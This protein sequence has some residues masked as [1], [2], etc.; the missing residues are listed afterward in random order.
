MKINASFLLITVALLIFGCV[1]SSPP[2]S[3]KFVESQPGIEG[4]D[5][6]NDP[7]NV[8]FDNENLNSS[9]SDDTLG[10]IKNHLYE[11]FHGMNTGDSLDFLVHISHFPTHMFHD[12]AMF[13]QQYKSTVHWMEQGFL[14]RVE[15]CKINYVSPWIIEESQRVALIGFDI[16]YHMDFLPHFPGNP[17]GMEN[18]VND[19]YGRNASK[20]TEEYLH[21]ESGDSVLIR[22]W[23][24][25]TSTGMFVLSPLDSLH[26]SFL[27]QDFNTAPF[28]HKLMDNETSLELL[29]LRRE[30][31]K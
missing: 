6:A 5:W 11:Y 10:I 12:T 13:E 20:Y 28:A 7:L 21:Y 18:V 26:F 1:N 19:R 14:N 17:K 29:R 8:S 27:P 9:I 23:H 25:H 16:D 22:N 2:V 30:E 4:F 24:T 3:E 15:N 31:T